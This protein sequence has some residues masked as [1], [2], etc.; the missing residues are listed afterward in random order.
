M[1]VGSTT[2]K[3]VIVRCRNR[4]DHL[5]GLPAARDQAAGKDA[6]IPEAHGGRS[7]HCS[8][9]LPHLH[10]RLGRRRA[11]QPGR[12]QVRAGSHRGLAG[13]RE[14]A[15]RGELRHRTGR[16]GRQDHR[17]QG[18]REHRPQE[19]DPVDERQ[20]RRRHRR[21]HRQDQRQAED[22]GRGALRTR[23]TP[24]SSCTRSPAS[25]A[26]SPRPTSTACRSRA[27]RPTS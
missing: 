8:A 22:S 1:D 3:A 17:L 10:H 7:R 6:G 23:A 20:V 24:A 12:R 4:P 25:A 16:A 2:V 9:Q 13:G 27:S 5:A 15:S 11:G 14:A 18:G 21:R 26:S 19:E